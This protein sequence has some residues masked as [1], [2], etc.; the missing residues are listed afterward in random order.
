MTER[1]EAVRRDP[2][3]Y[4]IVAGLVM[5]AF[6]LSYAYASATSADAAVPE[7]TYLAAAGGQEEA[8]C[9]CCDPGGGETVEGE[10][11]VEGE[12]QKA[13]VDASSGFAPNV[14]YAS[15]GMPLELTFS[16]GYG[17]MAEVLFR[18]F[19]ILE[20]LTRGGA[21][22]SLPALAPGEYVFSCG[23]EMVFGTLV[24]G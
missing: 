6:F 7:N 4:L 11:V 1:T 20:D 18:D 12:V 23:M 9:A 15:A 24:V 8:G 16:E 14:V 2:G 3:R 17:C 22:I 19:G 21:T 5:L 13:F 10:A